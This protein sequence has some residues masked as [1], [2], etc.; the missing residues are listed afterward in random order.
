MSLLFRMFAFFGFL[1]VAA[2]ATSPIV[3]EETKGS[4]DRMLSLDAKK[5]QKVIMGKLPLSNVK[6]SFI[7]LKYSL[8]LD[9]LKP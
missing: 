7:R 4:E 5:Y 1:G 8:K 9:N 6:I 2:C 3:P